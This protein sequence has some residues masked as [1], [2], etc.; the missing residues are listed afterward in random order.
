ME[1]GKFIGMLMQSRDMMHLTHWKTTNYAEHKALGAYYEGLIDLVD[2]F[3]ESYFG[4]VKRVSVEIPASKAT[5]AMS[6]LKAMCETIETE[7]PNYSS[8][9]QN[10]LDEISGL[11]HKTM[12]LLT[13]V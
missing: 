1:P 9:L 12:Y 3:A 6:H 7:R 8:D 10:I 5:D 4:Y 2:E 13:L 11:A